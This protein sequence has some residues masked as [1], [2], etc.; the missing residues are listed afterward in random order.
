MQVKLKEDG[1]NYTVTGS[2]ICDLYKQSFKD[3]MWTQEIYTAFLS[4]TLKE[5]ECSGD[6]HADLRMTSKWIL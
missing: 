5:S 3:T 4:E 1:E 6:L 2:K